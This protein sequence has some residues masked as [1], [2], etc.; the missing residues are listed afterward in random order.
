MK[1]ILFLLLFNSLNCQAQ[2]DTLFLKNNVQISFIDS[3]KL[4][5]ESCI[6]ELEFIKQLK[7]VSILRNT[8]KNIILL[9]FENRNLETRTEFFCLMK[10]TDTNFEVQTENVINKKLLV[11]NY[12]CINYF[13]I[14]K[15]EN[16]LLFYYF[17]EEKKTFIVFLKLI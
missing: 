1:K 11:N 5:S 14:I 10:L 2:I 7:T 12:F 4:T 3:T 6:F 17:D 16:E 8:T 9:N 15:S 13:K